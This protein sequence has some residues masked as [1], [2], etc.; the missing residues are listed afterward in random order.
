M[1]TGTVLQGIEEKFFDFL[2]ENVRHDTGQNLEQV[3]IRGRIEIK[4][5]IYQ[6]NFFGNAESGYKLEIGE[7]CYNTSWGVILGDRWTKLNPSAEQREKM[8][9]MIYAKVEEIE[10]NLEEESKE[11][12]EEYD[13]RQFFSY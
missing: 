7:F 6:I 8:Q 4:D 13:W 2:M 1:N 12:E 9:E 3:G 11:L 5:E 10:M